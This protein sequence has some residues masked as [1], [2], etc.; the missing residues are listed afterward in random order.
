[1][2]IAFDDF[3][4]GF[5]S[6]THLRDFPVNVLKIDRSFITDLT[7]GGTATT[8]VNAMVLLG[9]N[10]SMTVVAEGVETP[11]QAQFLKRIGCQMAQGY[12]FSK[13]IQSS[14]VEKFLASWT[15]NKAAASILAA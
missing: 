3:G 14:T 8:I 15:A 9:N 1:M 2:R 6:L 4:T 11:D 5:A 10:L 13:P 12:L 7:A